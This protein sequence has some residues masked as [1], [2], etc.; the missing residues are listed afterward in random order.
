VAHPAVAASPVA[1]VLLAV[2]V[3]RA[4]AELLA[5]A[6]R[7]VVAVPRVAAARPA[8]AQQAVCLTLEAV[9]LAVVRAVIPLPVV[10]VAVAAAVE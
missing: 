1:V 7:L 2:V 4:A 3:P 10:A 5:V 6:E 9:P 8:V